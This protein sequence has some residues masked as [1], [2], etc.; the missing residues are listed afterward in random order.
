M[1]CTT[2]LTGVDWEMNAPHGE[3][4]WLLGSGMEMVSQSDDGA[5]LEAL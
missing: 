1:R 4:P 2:C 3:L 5:V